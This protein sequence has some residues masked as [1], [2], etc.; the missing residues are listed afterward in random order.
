[1]DSV[2]DAE[3]RITD[4]DF[5]DRLK[6]MRCWLDA[7]RYAPS[8]FTYF[9]LFPGMKVRISFDN[10]HEAIA[11]ADQF[12]GIVVGAGG[13]GSAPRPAAAA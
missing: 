12:G 7:N 2:P 1:M 11:F 3:I 5:A 4:A 8:T 13:R 9:F 6:D 10:D